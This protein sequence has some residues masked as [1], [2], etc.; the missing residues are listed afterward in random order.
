LF[1]SYG[2]TL[3]DWERD[4]TDRVRISEMF[5]ESTPTAATG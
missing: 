1:E 5:S 3:S 2:L 4:R